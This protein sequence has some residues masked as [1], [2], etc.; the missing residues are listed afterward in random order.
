MESRHSIVCPV[1]RILTRT[2]APSEAPPIS[3]YRG[4]PAWDM[5]DQTVDFDL[6]HP[7]PEYEFDQ[8]VCW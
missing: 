7:E 4:T 1:E 5:L 6:I 2:G 3:P 8:S